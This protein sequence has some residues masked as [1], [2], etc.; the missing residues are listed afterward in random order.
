MAYFETQR[1][2]VTEEGP[3]RETV[4]GRV[5]EKEEKCIKKSESAD[6]DRHG[7]G[8]IDGNTSCAETLRESNTSSHQHLFFLKIV[9]EI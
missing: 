6:A 8:C 2:T 5:S 9:T 3:E 4:R 7:C 1:Q